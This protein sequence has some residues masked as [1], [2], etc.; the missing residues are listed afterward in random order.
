ML[1]SPLLRHLMRRG[2]LRVIDSDNQLH[3]FAGQEPW[4]TVTIRFHDRA[5]AR[6]LF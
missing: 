6:E 4:Q 3:I 2:T 5:V 1:A